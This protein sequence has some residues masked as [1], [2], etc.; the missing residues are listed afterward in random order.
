MW[1][2][3]H[4]CVYSR[5]P[6]GS[7]SLLSAACLHFLY[8]PLDVCLVVALQVWFSTPDCPPPPTFVSQETQ[9]F[10]LT[11]E[12]SKNKTCLWG[13]LLHQ[14][15]WTSFSEI[16]EIASCVS[17]LRVRL[18]WY[19]FALPPPPTAC[20]HCLPGQTDMPAAQQGSWITVEDLP[21][22]P[23]SLPLR[24]GDSCFSFG[25][26]PCKVEVVPL[27]SF[28]L[29]WQRQRAHVRTPAYPVS[30]EH[31]VD[32]RAWRPQCTCREL[33]DIVQV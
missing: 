23:L 11:F 8:V 16:H 1:G 13:A 20:C 24:V 32:L 29:A 30:L 33:F 25:V 6:C 28:P 27:T 2:E 4:R 14:W 12:S 17:A 26:S 10:I 5:C 18:S 7:S 31:H 15:M 22:L 21:A 19:N 3:K 9:C